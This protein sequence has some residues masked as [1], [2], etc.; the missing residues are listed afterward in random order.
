VTDGGTAGGHGQPVG[1]GQPEHVRAE[2][3]VGDLGSGRQ[4][5]R[6]RADEWP[7]RQLR[8]AGRGTRERPDVGE[9]VPVGVHA[10]AAVKTQVRLQAAAA[11]S[12][13]APYTSQARIGDRVVMKDRP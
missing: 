5:E 4:C 13:H 6:C 7:P 8:P 1:H 11:S 12:A 3:R 10:A 9:A 2:R